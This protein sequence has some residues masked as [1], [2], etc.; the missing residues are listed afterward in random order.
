MKFRWKSFYL[1]QS[2]WV[3]EYTDCISAKGGEFPNVCSAYDSKQS[4]D[5][6]SVILDLWGIQSTP[7]LPSLP[8]L[9]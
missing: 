6:A 8:G 7:S 5:E 3:A 2:A 1:P 4:E 9:F